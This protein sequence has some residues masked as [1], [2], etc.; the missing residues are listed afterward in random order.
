MSQPMTNEEALDTAV[1]LIR[2][3]HELGDR[4]FN[5]EREARTREH[6]QKAIETKTPEQVQE[7]IQGLREQRDGAEREVKAEKLSQM[8]QDAALSG[9]LEQC[10]AALEKCGECPY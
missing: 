1:E 4:H 7:M 6:L 9:A 3:H 5:P 8:N 10:N 2:Q